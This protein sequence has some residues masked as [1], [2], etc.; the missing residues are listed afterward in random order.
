MPFNSIKEKSYMQ[1]GG[2]LGIHCPKLHKALL[3]N[4][5]GEIWKNNFYIKILNSQNKPKIFASS[6]EVLTRKGQGKFLWWW[7][8]S[9]CLRGRFH[10]FINLSESLICTNEIFLFLFICILFS[11]NVS[12]GLKSYFYILNS[13]GMSCLTLSGINNLV[14]F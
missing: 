2:W 4:E 11:K 6:V 5:W 12:I 9:L 14:K 10:F 7:K 1:K 13:H 8:Y 3:L